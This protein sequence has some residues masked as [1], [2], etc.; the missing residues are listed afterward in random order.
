MRIRGAALFGIGLILPTAVFAQETQ[1]VIELEPIIV[2]GARTERPVSRTPATV[3]VVE[4]DEIEKQM[5]LTSNPSAIISRLI[6]GYSVSNQT[7]SGASETYRGRDLLVMLDGVPLN[8]PLRD[9]S[10]ILA[11]ID[12]NTVERIEFVSGA[13]SL[14]GSGATG[15]TVNFITKK[16]T[17]GKPIVRINTALR[18]FTA[19]VGDSLQPEI[20]ASITG[21][22][23]NGPDYVFVGSGRF[24]DKTYDGAGRELP[25][26]GMLG[27]GGGDRFES[28]NLF[29]KL[30]YDLDL[31][32]RFEVSANWI[33]LNQDP[34]WM[35][36]YLPP[37]ARPDFTRPYE[38][39][40]V[41]EDSKQISA[42][43]TDDDF[44]L[45]SLK[46][47][48][49]F[50]DVRK[51]FNYSEF[52]LNYNNVVYY[53]GNLGDPTSP[54]NQTDLS[55]QRGGVNLTVD[56]PLDRLYDGMRLT[57]GADI[58]HEKTSQVTTEGRD[59]FNPM[60]MM[61][62]A[63]F[64]QLEAP[65]T[66]RLT[67]RGG[68][69]YEYFDLTVDDFVRPAAFLGFPGLGYAVLPDLPVAGGEFDYSAPTFNLGGT[70]DLTETSQIFGGFSQG[71]ALPDVGSF[72]RRA[73]A[74]S[75]PQILFFGCFLPPGPLPPVPFNC[76]KN[77]TTSFDQISPEA[78][79]VNSYELGVRG[80]Y[81]QFKGSLVGFVS[82]SEEGV[83]FDPATNSLSQQKEIVWGAEFQGE[84]AM[85]EAFSLGTFLAYREG[86]FD[87]NKDGEYDSWLPNNRI[88][89]PFRAVVYGDYRFDNGVVFHL[90]GEG[91]AGRNKAVNPAGLSYELEGDFLVN[92]SISAPLAG[93]TFYLGV[94]N[95]FDEDYANP[96]ASSVRENAALGTLEVHG[97]GR[98]VS[99]GYAKTF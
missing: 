71:Y 91:W 6:P 51:R 45:G 39:K 31:G 11:L 7:I 10:R 35:T 76:A 92:T 78:Q 66:E 46:A 94:Q 96:T 80:S 73:G 69:R 99:L 61:T 64:G 19:N 22:A 5:Q 21:K 9:V 27:Q 38:G 72:T 47:V 43:Y 65:V 84:W 56:S 34:E 97:W 85:T 63:A 81:D 93:G 12:L 37:F 20:S 49:F 70:F 54:F 52:D 42:R 17:D 41:L 74:M 86:R 3:R 18:A 2:T 29:G 14:Y 77:L 88:A 62:Y 83:T 16:A 79:I 95:L 8:T 59:T 36:T 32:K 55:N 44:A 40:S 98:T 58:I 4:R 13:S 1:P 23:E 89:T 25:S 57:W 48:A 67:V 24:A 90:E 30:G 33:Y 75:T 60:S 53:S 50:N 87:Q 68:M 82:T 28:G 15:G 26:D